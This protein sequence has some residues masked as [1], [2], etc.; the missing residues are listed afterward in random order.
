[1]D[2]NQYSFNSSPGNGLRS[3]RR[4]SNLPFLLL[5]VFKCMS[6]DSPFPP[7]YDLKCAIN[8]VPLNSLLIPVVLLPR[9]CIDPLIALV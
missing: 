6:C 2:L 4:H 9:A 8:A 5:Q 1:M 3:K 7:F